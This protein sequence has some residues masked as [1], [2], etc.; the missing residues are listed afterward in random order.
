MVMIILWVESG[1]GEGHRIPGVGEH[2]C[3]QVSVDGAQGTTSPM[4]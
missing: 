3:V 1:G 2:V 4:A